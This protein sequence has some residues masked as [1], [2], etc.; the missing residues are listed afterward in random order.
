MTPSPPRCPDCGA[1]VA[2]VQAYCG[3][4]GSPLDT[5]PM[6]AWGASAPDTGPRPYDHPTAIPD[7]VYVPITVNPPSLR[8]RLR[9]KWRRWRAKR[10]GR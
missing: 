1:V 5:A 10:S 2:S 6:P 8:R 7:Q 4:C 9:R 3:V